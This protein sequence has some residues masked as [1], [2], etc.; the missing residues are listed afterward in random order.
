MHV[1]QPSKTAME[2]ILFY[3]Y[4]SREVG[5]WNAITWKTR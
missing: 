3:D 4:P 1:H 2:P 5:A